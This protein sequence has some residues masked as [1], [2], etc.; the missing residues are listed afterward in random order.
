VPPQDETAHDKESERQRL[1]RDLQSRY[2]ELAP[3]REPGASL[4]LEA[5]RRDR[6]VDRIAAPH[7]QHHDDPCGEERHHEP[8]RPRECGSAKAS[9]E[10]HERHGWSDLHPT[11]QREQADADLGGRERR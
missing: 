1:E 11:G 4:E 6:L 2:P 10:R 5:Q 7:H 3:N 9:D 8:Y